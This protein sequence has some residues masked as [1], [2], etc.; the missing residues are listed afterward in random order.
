MSIKKELVAALLAF[1][2]TPMVLFGVLIFKNASDELQSIRVAQLETVADL[3][4]D[5]IETFFNERI[6][7][8]TSAQSFYN[9]KHNLPILGRL[10]ND[11]S[12]RNYIRAAEMLYGQLKPF[13]EAAGYLDIIL[14]DPHGKIVYVTN[15]AR[16]KTLLGSPLPD[17]KAFDEGKKGIYFTDVFRH[18]EEGNR[19]EMLAAAPI[20]DFNGSFAG[21]VVFEID[22][23][24]IYEFIRTST[25]LGAT[26]E[27]LIVRQEGDSVLFLS[28]LLGDPDAAM[29]KKVAF[30]GGR[31]FPA[32]MAAKGKEGSGLSLDYG[33]VEV[34]A[35]WR[36]IPL[37]R[38]G[39]VTKITAAEAFAPIS[40]LRKLSIIIGAVISLL[41]VLVALL[42]ARSFSR[43]ITAL[44]KGAEIIGGGDLEYRIGTDAQ[45]EIG[46][47]SRAFD[48]MTGALGRINAELRTKAEELEAANKELEGFSY[49]VSHDLRAPLRHMAGFMELL[50]KRCGEQMDET[51]CRYMATIYASSKKMGMLIDDLLAF[52]RI[53]RAEMTMRKVRFDQLVKEAI[54]EMKEDTEG[55]DISWKIGELPEAWGDPSLL[56]LVLVN[57]ISNAVKFTGTRPHAEI[58]IGC[59]EEQNEFVFFVRDKGVGFDMKY[60]E[61]LF[62]VFQRLHRQDEFEGTGIG[63]A[64]VRRVVSRHGGRTWAEGAP[65]EGATFY[66]SLPRTTEDKK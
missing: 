9:I 44:Q 35:A 39:L 59:K 51:G 38:W 28:P 50:Q 53:G 32:Q 8:I 13:Q 57:L 20:Q 43:P 24:P 5:K 27:A 42:I 62:G 49:S 1:T 65:D 41:G 66:F 17:G 33:G 58:E 7:D 47:L 60:V 54:N 23:G 40:H 36:H 61:K 63:L 26:G 19:F 29:K 64:N 10:S 48:R 14:T 55:R 30:I 15:D 11:R 56:R 52:S 4:K 25:G 34:L 45:D 46:Q 2:I 18:R 31:G 3:K 6:V 21:E 37:L 12:N 22:M 16:G